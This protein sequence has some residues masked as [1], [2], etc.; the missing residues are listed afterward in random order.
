MKSL[1]FCSGST[2]SDTCMGRV[3]ALGM[4]KNIVGLIAAKTTTVPGQSLTRVML[5][6]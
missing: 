1:D 2:L 3:M 4:G 5:I 6:T